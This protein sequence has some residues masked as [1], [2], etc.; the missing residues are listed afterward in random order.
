MAY[1]DQAGKQRQYTTDLAGR[2][3]QSESD[4]IYAYF[5]GSGSF[6]ISELTVADVRA[7]AQK[8][9]PTIPEGFPRKF[10]PRNPVLWSKSD[11]DGIMCSGWFRVGFS[12]RPLKLW[13]IRQTVLSCP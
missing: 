3:G 11:K 5:K 9:K 1:L 10:A 6:L 13:M 4:P 12:I 2:P 8:R 7:L